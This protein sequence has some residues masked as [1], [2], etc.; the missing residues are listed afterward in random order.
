MIF[1]DTGAFIGRYMAGDQYHDKAS[2]AWDKLEKNHQRLFTSNL[3][4]VETATL[5]TRQAGY[6][7]AAQRVRNILDSRVIQILRPAEPQEREAIELLEKYADQRASFSDCLSFVLMRQTKI[8][9][10]FTF[11]EHFER[12]G[13]EIWP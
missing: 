5:L 12:A 11:D 8:K 7:F 6:G 4:I 13:F 2:H 9:T 1:I 10:A 3:V